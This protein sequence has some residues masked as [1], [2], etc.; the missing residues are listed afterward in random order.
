MKKL[1]GNARRPRVTVDIGPLFES[2]WTGIPV[3][4]R[5]LVQ[6]L[7]RQGS[8]DVDFAFRM[9][10]IPRDHVLA[11]IRANTG[12]FLRSEFERN[13]GN[14]YPLVD[15]RSHVLFPSVKECF[16]VSQYEA[17]TIHDV[18][19]L[20][21][22]ENHEQANID[23]HMRNLAKEIA[24][25]EV[26]FCISDATRAALTLAFPSAADKARVLSQYV[27]WP[28]NFAAIERNL[29]PPV[30]GRYATVIGTV[31]PRK[32]LALLIRA[33]ALPEIRDSDLRFVVIGREG[34]KVEKFMADLT[35]SQ[36]ERLLFSGFVT[37]FMKYRLL[38]HSEFLVYPS[39]YEGFGIPALEAM[40]LGKPVL[41]AMTSSLPEVIGEAGIYFD[42]LSV[43]EFA[44][45]LAEISDPRKSEELAP[46]A[47]EVAARFNWQ[48]MAAPI[49]AWVGGTK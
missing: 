11:A 20:V 46:K 1:A 32:N 21:M 18:S 41:G 7:L 2:Q 4:T 5:R 49:V 15:P 31:E 14:T 25:N 43:T 34:W 16:E 45:A 33:L 22:P 13:A 47:L 12:T 30:L 24:T 23:H 29:A 26:V 27:D 37:E 40:S 9:T 42:P 36:R 6:S 19:T 44:A 35:E 10:K 8:I 39:I 3:F 17:S 38:M 28:D 48:R